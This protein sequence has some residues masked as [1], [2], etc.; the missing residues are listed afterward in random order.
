[1]GWWK[2]SNCK[3]FAVTQVSRDHVIRELYKLD[4]GSSLIKGAEWVEIFVLTSC[5]WKE[6][7]NLEVDRP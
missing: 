7:L 6:Q 4:G 2:N 5:F 1:M 3:G